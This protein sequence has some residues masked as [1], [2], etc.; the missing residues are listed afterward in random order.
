MKKTKDK[1]N[2]MKEG[3]VRETKQQNILTGTVLD[4]T[5][6]PVSYMNIEIYHL[7]KDCRVAWQPLF[8]SLVSYTNIHSEFCIE[9]CMVAMYKMFYEEPTLH[10]WQDCQLQKIQAL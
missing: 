4:D 5:E 10:H 1:G 8:F 7:F 2:A 9:A 6:V 3:S